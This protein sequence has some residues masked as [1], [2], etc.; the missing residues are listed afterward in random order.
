MF[1]PH[2][3]VLCDLLLDRCTATWNLFLLHN[4]ET[5]FFSHKTC[6]ISRKARKSGAFPILTNTKKAIW[7]H[8]WFI[9]NEAI[10]LVAM[11]WQ[12]IVI[13]LSKSRHCQTWLECR[14]SSNEN[15][16]WVL[17]M[18]PN[19]PVRDQWEF[20]SK[21]ERHFRIKPGQPIGMTL[22][23]VCFSSEFPN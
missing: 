14:F 7:R 20:R 12:R 16:Q 15:L 6:F 4:K 5:N 23:T 9:Q 1:L 10:L 13:G 17:S 18:M 19:R 11:R 8:L 2:F 22:T 21:M 3:D